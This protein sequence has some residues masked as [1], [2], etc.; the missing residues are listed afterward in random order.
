MK[1][2][3]AVAMQAIRWCRFF[4]YKKWTFLCIILV[5]FRTMHALDDWIPKL[6]LY[7]DCAC[8]IVDQADCN[9]GPFCIHSSGPFCAF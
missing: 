6:V 7:Q 3:Q 9:S 2:G 5:I 8:S 4:A 1:L